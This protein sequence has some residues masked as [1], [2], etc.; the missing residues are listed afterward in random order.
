MALSLRFAARS[1]VGLVREGNEDSGYAGPHL[2]VIADGMGG[3]A[4]GEVASSV[5]VS[6]L[7]PLDD[8]PPGGDLLDRLAAAV[9]SANAQLAAMTST[10]PILEGMGTTVTAMLSV[11]SRVGL[12]HV[13][14]SRAY[15]LRHGQLAQITR[16]HTFVQSL[17]DEGRI[18]AEEADQHPQRSLIMRAL[19]GRDELELDLS[20]RE[21][22][23]GDRFLLCSD[24]LSGVV[25]TDTLAETL[26]RGTAADAV[27]ALV[28]LAL[29]AGGP[30]NITCVVADVVADDTIV[31]V[32]PEVVGAATD[33]RPL[34]ERD[35]DFAASRAAALTPSREQPPRQ[36]RHT[37]RSEGRRWLAPAFLFLLLVAVVGGGGYLGWKWTQQQY[38]VGTSAQHVAIFRGVSQSV[39]GVD[40]S[41]VQEKDALELGSLPDFERERVENTISAT[42]LSD[43]ESIVARLRGQACSAA[44]AKLP[45]PS[46][47]PTPSARAAAGR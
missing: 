18:S 17:V 33:E 19:D 30:D 36:H 29:R 42:S 31:A 8:D 5:V 27:E 38:Y 1:D 9:R 15:L 20:V 7:A 25:S 16:D 46:P 35:G 45:E 11:G 22:Q 24:G 23:P 41:R 39:V 10:D 47:S 44:E 37:E 26:R 40:L 43:A 6:A 12:V 2:L 4:A 21:V 14:D 3:H 34:R 32:D 28:E 13:G